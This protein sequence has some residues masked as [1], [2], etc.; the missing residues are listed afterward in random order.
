MQWGGCLCF[1]G[2]EETG[3]GLILLESC[4][5][6]RAAKSSGVAARLSC[7]WKTGPYVSQSQWAG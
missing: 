1:D 4:E 3:G 7:A 2:V 5:E 6:M